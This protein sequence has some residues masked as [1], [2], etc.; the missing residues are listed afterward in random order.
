[1]DSRILDLG[2]TWEWSHP[3]CFT[4]G[5]RVRGT[6]WIGGRVG[7]KTHLDGVER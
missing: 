4:P 6:H 2:T 3:D 5:E 7:S 1:M